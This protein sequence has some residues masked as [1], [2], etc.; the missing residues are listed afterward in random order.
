MNKIKLVLMAADNLKEMVISVNET[1]AAKCPADKA[2]ACKDAESCRAN[3]VKIIAA[4]NTL[5]VA[6]DSFA[7]AFNHKLEGSSHEEEAGDGI[8]DDI[9]YVIKGIINEGRK[10]SEKPTTGKE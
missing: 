1:A 10:A 2:A 6:L 9:L 7:E 5:I 3:D 4:A 8:L